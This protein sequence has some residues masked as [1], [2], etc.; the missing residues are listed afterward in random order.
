M[1]F[2]FEV[3]R[4]TYLDKIAPKEHIMQTI[5]LGIT[6]NHLSAIPVPIIGGF[7]WKKYG[8]SWTFMA[9]A[10]I[11]FFSLFAVNRIR[12]PEKSYLGEENDPS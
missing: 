7:I 11:L 2:G 12:T 9:G 3:A 6:V 8:Y 10:A 1:C 4:T 5:S